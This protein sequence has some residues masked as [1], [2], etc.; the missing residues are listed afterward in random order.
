MSKEVEN[1]NT[2]KEIKKI[3]LSKL[4]NTNNKQST[5]SNINNTK[6]SQLIKSAKKAIGMEG[7]AVDSDTS[8]VELLNILASE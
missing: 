8:M 7:V 3:L 1:T 5:S 6:N 4:G 2:L